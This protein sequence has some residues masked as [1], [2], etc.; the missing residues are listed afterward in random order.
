MTAL[1]PSVS[2]FSNVMP[3]NLLTVAEWRRFARSV[4]LRSWSSAARFYSKRE[5][6][7]HVL[8]ADD[9]LVV[10]TLRDNGKVSRS[11]YQPAK[12]RWAS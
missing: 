7:A 6:G 8:R 3:S 2:F 5:G 10:F 4:G 9:S 12:W 11:T 1:T